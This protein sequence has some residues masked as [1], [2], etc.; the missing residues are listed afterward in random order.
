MPHHGAGRHQMFGRDNV[1]LL[2]REGTIRDGLWIPTKFADVISMC[3]NELLVRCMHTLSTRAMATAANKDETRYS[4]VRL[5]FH[6]RPVGTK[7]SQCTSAGH[8]KIQ[9]VGC[10]LSHVK[11]R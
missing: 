9:T 7:A 11:V 3:L 4:V 1:F 5:G 6:M 10:E 8:T 2:L